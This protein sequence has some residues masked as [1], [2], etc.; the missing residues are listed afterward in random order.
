MNFNVS[1]ILF[2]IL[3]PKSNGGLLTVQVRIECSLKIR[4]FRTCSAKLPSLLWGRVG[5]GE[6]FEILLDQIP[7]I[8]LNRT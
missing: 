6:I 3:P 8:N 1:F 5:D 2:L 7:L 4:M